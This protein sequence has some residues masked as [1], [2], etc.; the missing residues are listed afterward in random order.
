MDY[1]KVRPSASQ[2]RQFLAALKGRGKANAAAARRRA[3]RRQADGDYVAINWAELSP[4]FRSAH[5]ALRRARGEPPIPPP[6]EDLY[7]PP[8]GRALQVP[9]EDDA[10]EALAAQLEFLAWVDHPTTGSSIAG[11]LA[12]DKARYELRQKTFKRY[13]YLLIADLLAW[14]LARPEL[15]EADRMEKNIISDMVGFLAQLGMQ[16][17]PR[18]IRTALRDPHVRNRLMVP[19]EYIS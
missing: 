2:A 5:N 3:K 17:C 12:L 4:A 19:R 6:R 7:T 1:P 10:R 16:C 18:T 11:R 15:T 9:T 13:K 14:H 8:R